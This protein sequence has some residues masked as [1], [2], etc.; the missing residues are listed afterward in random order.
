MT[1]LDPVCCIVVL[2]FGKATPEAQLA[3]YA[4]M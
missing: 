1:L 2:G 4:G 3:S